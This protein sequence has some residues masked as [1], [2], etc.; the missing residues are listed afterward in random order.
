VTEG[1]VGKGLG[2]L[3][4]STLIRSAAKKGFLE[5]IGV[6]PLPNAASVRL[7]AKWGFREA[8][9]LEGIGRKFGSYIDCRMMATANVAP[10]AGST[11]QKMISGFL[12]TDRISIHRQKWR[13]P[14]LICH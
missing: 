7:H 4:Y 9:R 2:T 11:G 14:V 5:L 3:L 13:L 8:G 6:I 12:N 10:S 1:S